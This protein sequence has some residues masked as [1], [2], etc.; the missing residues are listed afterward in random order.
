MRMRATF[1]VAALAALLALVPVALSVAPGVTVPTS[2]ELVKMLTQRGVAKCGGTA[3]AISE[4]DTGLHLS[5]EL[6]S[7]GF[8]PEEFPGY[9]GTVESKEVWITPVT[10]ALVPEGELVW[11][12]DVQDGAFSD[13]HSQ[14]VLPG[15]LAFPPAGT[16]YRHTCASYDLGTTT[17]GGSGP[18]QCFVND[19]PS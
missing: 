17:P 8:F 13:C 12:C 6:Q 10:D 3:P 7:T 1:A 18:W 15:P 19:R 5:L 14:S 4:C 2:G 16:I 11:R 9:T